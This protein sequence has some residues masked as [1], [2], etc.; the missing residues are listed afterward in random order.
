MNNENSKLQNQIEQ[1]EKRVS[2]IKTA[3]VSQ[4]YQTIQNSNQDIQNLNNSFTNLATSLNTVSDSLEELSSNISYND[5]MT[6][7]LSRNVADDFNTSSQTEFFY[8][9]LQEK[10]T[11]TEYLIPW[12][13]VVG[14]GQVV[15][16][17]ITL[18][19][20]HLADTIVYGKLMLNNKTISWSMGCTNNG[21][22]ITFEF[23][24]SFV[25]KQKNNKFTFAFEEMQDLTLLDI[26]IEFF[27]GNNPIMLNFSNQNQ[28]AMFDD[29]LYVSRGLRTLTETLYMDKM[30]NLAITNQDDIDFTTSSLMDAIC[31]ERIAMLNDTDWIMYNKSSVNKNSIG[32]NL[33]G[34]YSTY[35][36]VINSFIGISLVSSATPY[37]CSIIANSTSK[38]KYIILAVNY[39]AEKGLTLFA[40]KGKPANTISLKYNSQG[41]PNVFVDVQ[42]VLPMGTTEL[43]DG[44]TFYGYVAVREDGECIY[45]PDFD[46]TYYI[47]LGFGRNPFCYLDGEKI[48][49]TLGG[50][51][52]CKRVILAKNTNDVWAVEEQYFYKGIDHI[53]PI[54]NPYFV[55]VR[56]NGNLILDKKEKYYFKKDI[57]FVQY[58]DVSTTTE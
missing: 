16:G 24:F 9:T 20:I 44:E 13:F 56:K 7:N 12:H 42:A 35:N 8:T 4:I 19:G 40:T 54:N 25:P 45:F 10:Y 31:N 29:T 47:K 43:G 36:L 5:L 11:S 58:T 26:K 37:T 1:L 15:S 50:K 52:F 30:Q 39:V 23:N 49:I 57:Q 55:F 33:S 38:F 22:A 6:L 27:S 41:L 28:I 53:Y 48:V 17:K 18:R 14:L 46:S 3:D 51:N 34:I 32:I 2:N 21:G